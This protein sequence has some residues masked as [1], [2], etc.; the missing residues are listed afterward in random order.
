VT[1]SN[2]LEP[3]YLVGAFLQMNFTGKLIRIEAGNGMAH[4]L[5]HILG[6]PILDYHF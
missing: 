5:S 3:I 1:L 2:P 6:L 4:S